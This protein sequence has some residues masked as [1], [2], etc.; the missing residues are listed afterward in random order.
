[1]A[2]TLSLRKAKNVKLE[3]TLLGIGSFQLGTNTLRSACA[4]SSPDWDF[5]ALGFLAVVHGY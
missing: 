1:M 5:G 2:K 4:C 3:K